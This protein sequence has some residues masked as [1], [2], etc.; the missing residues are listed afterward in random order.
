[1]KYYVIKLVNDGD[2]TVVSAWTDDLNGAKVSFFDTC[3]VLC[4]SSDV[5]TAYVAIVDSQLDTVN[6]YKEFISHPEET[7]E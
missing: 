5:I 7:T 6:N 4:N 3:K 2:L 1:M